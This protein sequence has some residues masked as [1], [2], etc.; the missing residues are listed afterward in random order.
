MVT[1]YYNKPPQRGL[2]AHFERV[3]DATELP[4]IAYNIPGRTATRI[5]HDTL[6]RLAER[7]NIVAVKDS[8]GDFQAFSKLIA[9]AP[10]GFEVYSGDDWAAFGYVCLGAVGVVSVASH[11]VGAQIHQM[12]DLIEHRRRPGRAQDPRDSSRRSSTRCSSRRTR[13]RSR[14]PSSCWAARRGRRACRSCPRPPRNAI[15]SAP[16]WRTPVSC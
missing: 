5:E 8:T 1:P 4:I 3:A 10:S 6:L 12:I 11:L 15:A 16:R 14:P 2:I 13:S 9:E 7:P